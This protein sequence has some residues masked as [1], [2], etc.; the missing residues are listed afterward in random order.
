MDVGCSP[1]FF[2]FLFFP[3]RL[4]RVGTRLQLRRWREAIGGPSVNQSRS[5]SC[6][7]V[8]RDAM[9]EGERTVRRMSLLY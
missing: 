2:F 8:G 6:S 1:P 7:S 5:S 3:H 4:P 9:F